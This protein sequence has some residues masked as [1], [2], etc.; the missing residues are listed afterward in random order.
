MKNYDISGINV[1]LVEKHAEMRRM[2]R[3][4]LRQFNI[5]DVRDCDK[6]VDALDMFKQTEF[7]LVITDW[8]PGLDGIELLKKLRQEDAANPFIPVV[9]ISANTEARH[10]YE[11][12][13]SGM[14]E[15]LAKP[16]SATM[17]YS[18]ICSVIE[19]RRM[20]ISNEEF[21]G[22]DRR[23]LRKADYSGENRR[24]GGNVNGPERRDSSSKDYAG[25]DR[26]K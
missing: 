18:R 8:A 21:F 16:I 4:I 7:D 13:D 1:L 23:R 6:V 24:S 22:P 3:D 12:L 2:I 15:F 19:K 26:R 17:L 20:F 10:I 5:R 14:T 25:K 9:I 11:A